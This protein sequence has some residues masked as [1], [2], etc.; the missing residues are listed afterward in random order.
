MTSSPNGQN[1]PSGPFRKIFRAPPGFKV[2]S[3][4]YSAIELRAAALLAG[5]GSLLDVFRNPPRLPDRSRNPEGDPHEALT[6]TLKLDP[7]LNAGH[8]L[9]KI[10]NF[11]LLYGTGVNGFAS[12]ANMPVND[13]RDLID[14]WQ[15][16][17]PWLVLWQRR[18]AHKTQRENYVVSTPVGRRVNCKLVDEDSNVAFL[19]NRCLNV[20]IQGGCAEALM[21]ALPLARA[22]LQ[23]IA[24]PARLIAAVHDELVFECRDEDVEAASAAVA[25]AMAEGFKAVFG[26]MNRF[27]DAAR[28]AVGTPKVGQTWEGDVFDLAALSPDEHAI[29]VKGLEINE[30]DEEA[31]TEAEEA[32]AAL[33]DEA[34]SDGVDL[35]FLRHEIRTISLHCCATSV[36]NGFAWP[37]VPPASS[38]SPKPTPR[39]CPTFRIV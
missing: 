4:D 22:G 36:L 11:R 17:R 31:D 16:V 38:F 9:A 29:L 12:T 26:S 27:A 14:R 6:R 35:D 28:Y 21:V 1:L 18:I 23:K 32:K 25:Q 30:D 34:E 5:E 37:F 39:P 15:K 24:R 3:I 33:E 8:R 20:P 13:A 2:V 10:L 19:R 7:A